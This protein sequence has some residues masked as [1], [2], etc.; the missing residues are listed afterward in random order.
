MVADITRSKD[1]LYL[2]PGNAAGTATPKD[3]PVCYR[4]TKQTR[5][6]RK[7]QLCAM[8]KTSIIEE[9]GP[10]ERCCVVMWIG[11]LAPCTSADVLI[12]HCKVAITSLPLQQFKGHFKDYCNTLHARS[13]ASSVK[14]WS[15]TPHPSPQTEKAN[16]VRKFLKSGW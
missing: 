5:R 3:I 7:K 12:C 10:W 15:P 9:R 6:L 16:C 4:G 13:L 8:H 2:I 1:L 14:G 11:P